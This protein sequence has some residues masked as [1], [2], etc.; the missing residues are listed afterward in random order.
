MCSGITSRKRRHER[1]GPAHSG[2]RQRGGGTDRRLR[3]ARAHIRSRCTRRT[4][5]SAGTPTPTTSP[6][7]TAGCCRS[8][9]G[10]IVHNHR[11]YPHLLRLF[12]RTGR[13][14]AGDGDEHVRAVRGLRPGVRRC[15]RSRAASSPAPASLL[16]PRYLRMLAEIPRFHR[17]GAPAARPGRG[18]RRPAARRLPHRRRLL[19]LLRLALH[20]A[21]GL[22]RVVLR[23]G[24][25]P[26]LPRPLPLPLPRPPRPA[27]CE[28]L[29]DL[30]H[31]DRRL[32]RVRRTGR[33][34]ASSR[35]HRRAR[36][37]PCADT[38]T[39]WR[40]PTLPGTLPSSTR[41]SSP[42]TPTRH[43]GCWP[44]PPTRN[45]PC[46]ARSATRATRPCCTPTPRCCL[47]ARGARASW[48]YLMPSCAAHAE[49]VQVSYDM[50]RL[51][52]ARRPRDVRGHPERRRPRRR[53]AG[54][55]PHGLR[56]PRLHARVGRGPAASAA[57]VRAARTAFAGAYHGWGF[58]EDGCRSGVE[59][60]ARP[61]GDLV[62]AAAPAAV[63]AA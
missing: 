56:T 61:G 22:R 37:A 36:S 3:A 52:R 63:P 34:A 53:R 8:T 31:R 51:Q 23:R 17:G 62:S 35:A 55:R 39:A 4:T 16:R 24:H 32:T 49:Q 18:R 14:D 43:C 6:P 57:A 42:P 9:P 30:A 33:Q 25:R 40:S 27:L 15:P 45:A 48:N 7:R 44:T 47:A 13:G 60:A 20:D 59:A 38:P 26:A 29:A 21:A 28:E 58:H 11:T 41:W 2:D 1:A 46:S 19:P 10:F 5:G 54:A 12:R 50:N